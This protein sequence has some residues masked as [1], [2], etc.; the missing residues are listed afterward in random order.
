[1]NKK[2]EFGQQALTP[3]WPWKLLNLETPEPE[4][5]DTIPSAV[6]AQLSRNY[7]TM[8]DHAW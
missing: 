8:A 4:N 7:G 2:L 5:L 6:V 3:A 1:L